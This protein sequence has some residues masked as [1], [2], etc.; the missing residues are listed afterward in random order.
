MTEPRWLDSEA[1]GD[2]LA[3]DPRIVR[4]RIACRP[5]FPRAYRIDGK[6]HP[7]WRSDEVTEWMEQ[8]KANP[9]AQQS[10]SPSDCNRPGASASPDAQSSGQG[11]GHPTSEQAA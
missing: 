10:P 4:E 5:D 3:Y 7:R 8:W 6:G 1:V 9:S 11:R 2:L